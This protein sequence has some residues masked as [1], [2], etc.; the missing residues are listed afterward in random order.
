MVTIISFVIVLGI[1]IF[2]HEFGHFIAARLCGVGVEKFSIG[3]GPKVFGWKRGET[4]YML[5]AIPLGG[6]VKMIGEEPDAPLTEDEKEYSFTHKEVWKRFI[7]VAAGPFFNFFLAIVLYFGLFLFYGTYFYPPVIGQTEPGTPSYERLGIGDEI[8]SIND[9][10]ITS[11]SELEK[12]IEKSK[13]NDLIL[14]VK[15][16]NDLNEVVLKPVL[17]DSESIFGEKIKKYSIGVKPYLPP[18]IGSIAPDSPALKAGIEPGDKIIEINSQKIT[19]W[20]D[21]SDAI[22]RSESA[23]ELVFERDNELIKKTI[24]P[25]IKELKDHLG[26]SFERKL[27]GIAAKDISKHKKAGPLTAMSESLSQ[28]WKVI[29]LT[30]VGIVKMIDGTISKDNLGGPIMIAQMAGDQAKQGLTSFLIFICLISINLGLLNL[31]PVPVL[32][33]GHLM[34]FLIEMVTGKPVSIKV[35]EVA[36]QIGLFLLLTLMVFAFYNDILRLF[37]N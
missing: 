12:K 17:L 8:V 7:I 2:V 22:S 32:D 25:E 5:S 33:G 18:V 19:T 9:N 21:V 26:K 15:R 11:W 23:I 1:L 36:Q 27:I 29:E 16:G 13:G 14:K 6:Y 24:Q 20:Y 34:F 4:D 30:F 31:L 28:T 35:R 10:E 37:S 3:F